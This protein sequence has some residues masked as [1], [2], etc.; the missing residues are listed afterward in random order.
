MLSVRSI[1][2]FLV[3]TAVAEEEFRA[4]KLIKK[5]PGGIQYDSWL[6]TFTSL[7]TNVTVASAPKNP[8]NP[9]NPAM[10]GPFGEPRSSFPVS[11][12]TLSM[13][14]VLASAVAVPC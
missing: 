9:G 2:G 5:C 13:P 10:E 3:T 1:N 7:G 8:L 12:P 11:L 4:I 14:V 6:P